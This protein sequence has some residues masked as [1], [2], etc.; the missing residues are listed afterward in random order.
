[1]IAIGDALMS[2]GWMMN[3]QTEPESLLLMLS[4]QHDSEVV[5]RYAAEL[6]E[7]TAA[8]QQG[9]LG[10]KQNDEAYGIY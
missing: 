7:V 4:A 6:G 5:D 8:V 2:R 1:M 9:R 3:L 10:R